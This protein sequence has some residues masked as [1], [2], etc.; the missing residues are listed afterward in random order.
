MVLV[1]R[2]TIDLFAGAGGA[3]IGLRN[4]GFH[5]E[6]CIEKDKD[7]A[8]T[9]LAAGL[10]GIHGDVRDLSHYENLKKIA[11]RSVLQVRDKVHWMNVMV[12][13]GLLMSLIIYR[14]EA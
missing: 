3:S 5:H 13:H 4:A 8:S 6:L 7:A 9:L 2:T 1:M 12:G 14:A 10:P 11:K